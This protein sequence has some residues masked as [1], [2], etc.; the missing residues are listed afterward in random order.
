MAAISA[1][2]TVTGSR[3]SIL[4]TMVASGLSRSSF[5][6]AFANARLV[7]GRSDADPSS[8]LRARAAQQLDAGYFLVREREPAHLRVRH[9]REQTLST[10]MVHSPQE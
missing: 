9:E 4:R 7:L 1:I 5:S 2:K 10:L 8:S 6:R 3:S